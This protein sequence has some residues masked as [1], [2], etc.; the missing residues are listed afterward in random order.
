MHVLFF[1]ARTSPLLDV[2][3]AASATARCPTLLHVYAG[4]HVQLVHDMHPGRRGV[5]AQL[6]AQCGFNVVM[7]DCRGTPNR[8][9]EFESAYFRAMVC[10]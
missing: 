3:A 9:I 1:P 7:M 4:P 2:G 10:E 5:E 8:G 6:Y